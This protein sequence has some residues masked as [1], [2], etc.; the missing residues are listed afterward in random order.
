MFI[1]KEFSNFQ[2]DLSYKDKLELA[3]PSI[4]NKNLW[5]QE[6]VLYELALLKHI[7]IEF[8]KNKKW[9]PEDITSAKDLCLLAFSR[10]ILPV[11]N[12]HGE[13][14]YKS[15]NKHIKNKDAISKFTSHLNY[16]IEKIR[17]LNKIKPNTKTFVY[18]ADSRKLDFINDD[19]CDFLVT[20]PPYLSSWDY[21]LYHKFRFIW[22]DLDIKKFNSVEIGKHLRREGN[23]IQRYTQD[24][25]D[26]LKEFSRI[27]T[28]NSFC[29]IVNAPSLLNKK[30]VDTNNILIEEA[31]KNSLV[32]VDKIKRRTLGPHYGLQASLDSKEIEVEK[33]AKSKEKEE[34]IL[35]FRNKK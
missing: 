28:K 8:F 1:T 9:S 27:L 20:S 2:A 10:I 24:M 31:R 25:H 3:I 35:I 13:S 18:H 34:T 17:I 11:S 15:I 14:K 16:M 7:I 5:F 26:C 22:L 6:N 30:Y 29:C 19:F 12:Q 33:K 4:H 21:A 23:E 32:L